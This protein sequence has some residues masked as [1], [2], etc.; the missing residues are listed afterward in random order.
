MPAS[1]A[2]GTSRPNDEAASQSFGFRRDKVRKLFVIEPQGGDL[3]FLSI[4]INDGTVF[5]DLSESIVIG[6]FFEYERKRCRGS[7][8]DIDRGYAILRDKDGNALRSVHKAREQD[9]LTG[10]LSDG[11][12]G[13]RVE[14]IEHEK[15]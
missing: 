1:E 15:S 8:G 13:L 7:Q 3:E 4:L 11:R 6:R 2:G 12:L 10:Q 5:N 9:A 14:S